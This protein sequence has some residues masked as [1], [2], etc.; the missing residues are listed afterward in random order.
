MKLI[1]AALA[2]ATMPLQS[3]AMCRAK[4]SAEAAA[5]RRAAAGCPDAKPTGC[6]CS[7]HQRPIFDCPSHDKTGWASNGKKCVTARPD[8]SATFSDRHDWP[9]P[10]D[11]WTYCPPTNGSMP[12]SP[13]NLTHW[14]EPGS[15]ACTK[16]EGF[17]H[18]FASENPA[19]Y[20][21]KWNSKAWCT[22]PGCFVD[23]CTC[24]MEDIAEST[25]FKGTAGPQIYYSY[26]QCGGKDTFTA[27]V[28]SAGADE[29][30]CIAEAGCK[31]LGNN[32]G[33]NSSV[34][35]TSSGDSG[36]EVAG[37]ASH[38]MAA[39]ALVSIKIAV[40]TWMLQ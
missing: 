36:I 23:P 3:L 33:G 15:Y 14:P 37:V 1:A 25:W 13:D 27:A 29:T 39:T 38:A 4:T 22:A 16:V 35:A 6:T 7:G 34:N 12:G 9:Y 24:N 40:A 20:N 21:N 2:A 8:V 17:P 5:A 11:Y 19:I 30:T 10:A 31:W 28:C 26:A 18:S 32:T